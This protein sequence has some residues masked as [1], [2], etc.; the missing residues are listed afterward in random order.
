MGSSIFVLVVFYWIPQILDNFTEA[1]ALVASMLGYA[2][3]L[4]TPELRTH[5]LKLVICIYTLQQEPS[6][7]VTSLAIRH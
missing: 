7:V 6:T 3:G 1:S 5:L 4:N 2:T